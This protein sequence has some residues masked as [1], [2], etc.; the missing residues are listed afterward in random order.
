MDR[1]EK[2]STV[3]HWAAEYRIL[4]ITDCPTEYGVEGFCYHIARNFF[5]W[6]LLMN[7]FQVIYSSA[8]LSCWRQETDRSDQMWASRKCT[9]KMMYIFTYRTRA[10]E[11]NGTKCAAHLDL[12]SGDG[13]LHQSLVQLWRRQPDFLVQ[14]VNQFIAD[15]SKTQFLSTWPHAQRGCFPSST[16]GKHDHTSTKLSQTRGRQWGHG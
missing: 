3:E 5:E 14:R 2:Q 4:T 6:A 7:G 13:V 8:N 15:Y 16:T 12:P 1:S 10:S 9:F 11:Q